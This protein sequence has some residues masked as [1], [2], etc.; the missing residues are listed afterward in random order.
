VRVLIPALVLLVLSLGCGSSGDEEETVQGSVAAATEE[1]TAVPTAAPAIADQLVVVLDP[2][3][4]GPE[5]G[6]AAHD[7]VEKDSNLDLAR[8]VERL[9]EDEGVRVE[10]TRTADSR[11]EGYPAGRDLTGFAS[12]RA[13]L[14][15]RVD[16]ANDEGADL[17]LSIHS[18]GSSDPGQSGV[19]VWYDPNRPFGEENRHLADLLQRSTLSELS[20]YGYAANDRGLKDD[21]CFRN[22]SGRCFPLF[23]LGPERQVRREEVVARGGDPEALGFLPEQAVISTRATQM[24]GALVELLF[25]TNGLDSAVLRDDAGREALARGVAAGVLEFLAIEERIG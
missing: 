2:G 3:H 19:E 11:A 10:L 13:D 1:P 12:T 23:V 16:I 8:R 5:V 14:Q 25:I 6:A 9:L 18:N 15:A 21:T 24:P 7:V 20:A 22:R 4:G 17:F